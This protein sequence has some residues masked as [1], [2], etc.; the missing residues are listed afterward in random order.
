MEQWANPQAIGAIA[1]LLTAVVTSIIAFVK[2]RRS[3]PID[4]K[5][6]E[7]ATTT[8]ITDASKSTVETVLLVTKMIEDDLKEARKELR[9]WEKWY[10]ILSDTWGTVRQQK[11][12]PVKPEEDDEI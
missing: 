3:A 4:R 2:D 9:G 8:V 12:P 7:L 5:T 11:Y 6:A 10:S 1:A